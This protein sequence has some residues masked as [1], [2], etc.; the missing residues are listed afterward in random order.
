MDDKKIDIPDGIG[1]NIYDQLR[2]RMNYLFKDVLD[3]LDVVSGK[4]V[5][6]TTE[7][8]EE[9]FKK[10]RKKLLDRGNDLLG[11]LELFFKEVEIVG[12][13]SIIKLSPK[14]REELKREEEE[15]K[16]T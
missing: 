1:K 11:M 15:K 13:K 2:R 7:D 10:I 14:V 3:E 9:A 8:K 5:N 4:V 16:E 6:F 12:I